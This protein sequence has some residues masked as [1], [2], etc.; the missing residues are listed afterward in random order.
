M[1]KIKLSEIIISSSEEK[2]LKQVLA[3]GWLT[4]GEMSKNVEKIIKNNFNFKYVSLTNSCTSGIH[5]ALIANNIGNNQEVITSPMTFVSTI[6]SLFQLKTKII[7]ADIDLK[8]FNIDIENVKKLINSKT[9]C[10]LP[11]HYGGIPAN[12]NELLKLKKKFNFKIIED[13]AT[14]FGSKINDQFIGSLPTDATVFSFYANK[15]I[16]SAEGGCV[17]T[18]NKKVSEKIKKIIFCGINKDTFSRGKGQGWKYK[19]TMPGYKYNISDIHSAILM[20]QLEKFKKIMSKRL[21]LIKLYLK[22]FKE[23]EENKILLELKRNINNSSNY[24]FPILLNKKNIKTTRNKIIS[25]LLD[26][27]ISSTVHYIPGNQHIFYKKIFKKFN[28]KNTNYA[29]NN[30]I[31][32]PL[33]NKLEEE[34]IF[35]IY[36]SFKKLF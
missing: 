16:T 32:L 4:Y 7:L 23:F 22:Y 9:S 1:K 34:D 24:I 29:Y 19:V 35:Y 10:L 36:K 14:A 13:A 25:K 12:I 5:A 18:N 21:E 8:D 6:N 33:H 2:Y 15:I 26:N 31:S 30:I 17:V 27:G 20:G 3:S 11:T 28:L